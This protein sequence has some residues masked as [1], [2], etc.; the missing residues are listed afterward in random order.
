MAAGLG[1]PCGCLASFLVY[2]GVL[3]RKKKGLKRTLDLA[4]LW[5]FSSSYYLTLL[6]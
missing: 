5:H 3:P 1:L 2:E 4:Y 6:R